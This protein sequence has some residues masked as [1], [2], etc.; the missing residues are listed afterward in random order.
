MA[1][2]SSERSVARPEGEAVSTA[3]GAF[4]PQ[5]FRWGSSSAPLSETIV[6]VLASVVMLLACVLIIVALRRRDR[7][8][9]RVEDEW[10]A[11]T[12][13]G[14]LCPHGWQAHITVR[15]SDAPVP[16]DAPPWRVPLVELEWKQFG[17]QPG[18]VEVARRLWAATIADALQAMVDDRH[19]DVSL[20]QIERASA[21]RGQERGRE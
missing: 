15:G 3:L 10:Q 2:P 14:E 9:G 4:A 7:R 20:E 12:V 6:L 19:T 13:M 18:R 5:S 21:E 11:Q 16:D 8:P 1:D 17:E